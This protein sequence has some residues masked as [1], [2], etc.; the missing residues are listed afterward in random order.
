MW[1]WARM[2][3]QPARTTVTQLGREIEPR[4]VEMDW[5]GPGGAFGITGQSSWGTMAA[6][7]WQQVTLATGVTTNRS[8]KPILE[9]T[10]EA[11]VAGPGGSPDAFRLACAGS[12]RENGFEIRPSYDP[13]TQRL[14]LQVIEVYPPSTPRELT[15][16]FRVAD[17]AFEAWP[18]GKTGATSPAGG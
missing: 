13:T 1:T 5:A 9:W 18:A 15:L 2:A 4:W 14:D 12:C 6:S 11:F 17:G 3:R 7:T 10:V 16:S 8:E